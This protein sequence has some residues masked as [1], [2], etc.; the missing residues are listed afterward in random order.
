[1]N[2]YEFQQLKAL[3]ELAGLQGIEPIL[4][5]PA[6]MDAPRLGPG[7]LGPGDPGERQREQQEGGHAHGRPPEHEGDEA[8]VGPALPAAG[9]HRSDR[10]EVAADQQVE[11]LAGAE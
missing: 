9:E 3:G 8:T 4:T 10:R 7:R 2:I 5:C 11:L 6:G 1:M